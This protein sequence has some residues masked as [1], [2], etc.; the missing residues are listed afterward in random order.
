[1]LTR[2]AFIAGLFVAISASLAVAQPAAKPA[3]EDDF[4]RMV[5]F[6]LPKDVVLEVGGMDWLDAEKTRL[7]V[8]TRRGEV[9]VLDNVYTDNPALAGT[10]VKVQNEDGKTVEVEATAAQIVS[11]KRMLF[12][13]HEPLGM[14]VNPKDFPKGIYMVQRSELTRSRRH[15]RRRPHRHGANF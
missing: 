3:T 9:W 8:C 1:M 15:Q 14:V 4:Y 6:P 7:A 12:G 11:Y 13:L 2:N 5:T 10:K